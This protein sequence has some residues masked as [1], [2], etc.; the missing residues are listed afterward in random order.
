MGCIVQKFGG[1]SVA[2]LD[3]IQ[4]VAEIIAKSKMEGN[5]VVAVVS[6][7]AGTTNRLIEYVRNLGA[8]EGEQEYDRVIS[9]GEMITA[10]LL[11]IALKRIGVAAKSYASWQVPILTDDMF[12]RAKIKDVSPI[13]LQNNIRNGV[14]PVVCG[15]QG[16]TGNNDITTLGR[17]GSDLTA[18]AVASALSAVCEIYSDVDG[19]YTVDPNL[20]AKAVRL[21]SINYEEMLEMAAQGAKVLQEQS[22][23]YAKE[24]NVVVRVVS[25]F[26]DHGGTII[27]SN[28][29]SRAICGLAITNNL[30]HLR[31]VYE[32]VRDCSKDFIS[33]LKQ[34]F[35]RAEIRKSQIGQLLLVLDRKK[36]P[37]AKSIL[38][39][40]SRIISLRQEVVRQ[41]ISKI[42]IIGKDINESEIIKKLQENRFTV[43]EFCRTGTK[44]NVIVPAVQLLKTIS[45]LHTICGLDQ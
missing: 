25:S 30:A 36:I 10:G 42:S 5:E 4:R 21:E 43:V 26:V 22:V 7:M 34:N 45:F 20:Y 15:F 37:S 17:G 13:N 32:D 35:I 11:A 19:V 27:S 2:T 12:G 8:N 18:V 29:G 23:L 39:A 44:L 14:V 3:R 38:K 6:A 40:D 28:V 31:I 16:I 33:I 1:T 24:K 41:A 9:S